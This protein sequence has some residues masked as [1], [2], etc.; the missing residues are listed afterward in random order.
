MVKSYVRNKKHCPSS[1]PYLNVYKVQ[2]SPK[3]ILTLNVLETSDRKWN[4][5]KIKSKRNNST[6]STPA[7][8][9]GPNK[10]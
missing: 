7:D 10:S 4:S 9:N 2:G 6:Q 1:V 3:Q 5:K 8:P